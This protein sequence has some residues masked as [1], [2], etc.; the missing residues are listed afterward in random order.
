MAVL[1]V[2]DVPEF[3]PLVA[4]AEAV[5]LVVSK[6]GAYYKIEAEEELVILR[7]STGMDAAI[8]FGG[9][10]GGYEG[11]VLEFTEDVLRIG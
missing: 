10:V 3:Q 4:Y 8:W 6:H 5:D 7:A 1:Y 2:V 9:L 11:E